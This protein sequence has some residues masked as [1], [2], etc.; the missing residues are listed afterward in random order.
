MKDESGGKIMKEFVVQRPKMY[1]YIVDD[2]HVE[3]RLQSTLQGYKDCL[4][5]IKT[6][7]R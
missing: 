4:E 1:S 6:I 5:N 2:D 3:I 7:I